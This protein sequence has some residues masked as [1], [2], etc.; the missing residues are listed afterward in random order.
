MWPF[1]EDVEEWF[2]AVRAEHEDPS[3]GD[4]PTLRNEV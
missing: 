2:E 1:P 3:G 4:T